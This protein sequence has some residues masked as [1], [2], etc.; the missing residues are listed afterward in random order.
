MV[1]VLGPEQLVE[2]VRVVVVVMRGVVTDAFRH[3]MQPGCAGMSALS[4]VA[5]S[6]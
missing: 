1:I 3:V 2:H 6:M 5:D 4:P